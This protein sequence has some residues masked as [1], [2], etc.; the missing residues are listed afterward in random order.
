MAQNLVSQHDKK[1][2]RE[3]R[4]FALEYVKHIVARAHELSQVR[5]ALDEPNA[6]IEL[7]RIARAIN[8]QFKLESAPQRPNNLLS[9]QAAASENTVHNVVTTRQ[10]T[11]PGAQSTA[12]RQ[13]AITTAPQRGQTAEHTHARAQ[14]DE[15]RNDEVDND[16]DEQRNE[17]A[18]QRLDWHLVVSCFA[19]CLPSALLE[20]AAAQ[21]AS[22]R[23]AARRQEQ[24]PSD[25]GGGGS[26]KTRA[27]MR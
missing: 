8:A 3:L 24:H 22:F 25:A 12:A 23:A 21:A 11:K 20:H 13:E 9:Q 4:A 17:R 10:R 26:A 27:T 6:P 16:V 18:G 15:R 5:C 19:S 14:I 1:L 7:R 2:V